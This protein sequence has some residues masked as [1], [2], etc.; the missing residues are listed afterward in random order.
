MKTLITFSDITG[1]AELLH[2]VCRRCERRGQ[3]RLAR[4][5]ERYGRSAAVAQ[6]LDDVS[7]DCPRRTNP[8]VSIYE[9]CQAH[10]PDL[11]RLV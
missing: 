7:A 6:F 5:V 10:L 4:L 11:P 8:A 3:Y 1:R 2:V 9:R